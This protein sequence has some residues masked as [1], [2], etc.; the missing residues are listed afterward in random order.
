LNISDGIYLDDSMN[1]AVFKNVGEGYIE[2]KGANVNIGMSSYSFI[3]HDAGINYTLSL[4]YSVFS[5]SHGKYTDCTCKVFATPCWCGDPMTYVAGSHSHRN[6]AN[7]SA[8]TG[9]E[10]IYKNC[11]GFVTVD[12][13]IN[14]VVSTCQGYSEEDYYYNYELSGCVFQGQSNIYRECEGFVYTQTAGSITTSSSASMNI[15][16][17]ALNAGA[18]G[19]SNSEFYNC[20]FGVMDDADCGSYGIYSSGGYTGSYCVIDNCKFPRT[21][22][23]AYGQTNYNAIPI[24]ISSYSGGGNIA[25]NIFSNQLLSSSW[26]NTVTAWGNI[27]ASISKTIV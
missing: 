1:T 10:N 22:F 11:K 15:S 16:M 21:T 26:P 12:T 4:D 3:P 27:S 17:W 23:Q 9:S 6:I 5:G 7:I 19:V 25:N 8:Y 18:Y 14:I 2:H 24:G 13:Q 20:T